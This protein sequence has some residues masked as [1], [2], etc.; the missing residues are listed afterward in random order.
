MKHTWTAT[1]FLIMIFII[2]QLTGLL[3]INEYMDI[4]ESSETGEAVIKKEV[5]DHSVGGAPPEVKNK[6]FSAVMIM[7]AIIVGTGILLLLIKYRL[8]RF[9]KLWLFIAIAICLGKAFSPFVF[10]FMKNWLPSMIS[11]SSLIAVIF[12]ILFGLFKLYRNNVYIHNFTEIFIYGGLC[13]FVVPILNIFWAALLL[14]GISFYDMYAVWHSKHMVTMAKFQS[15]Q[16]MFAG[17]MIPYS[18]K[19]GKKAPKIFT[20]DIKIGKTAKESDIKTA[21]LGGG[22]IAFPLIFSGV[23]LWET[24]S[25][26]NSFIVTITTTAALA[27]LFYIGEKDKFYPAMPFISAGVFLGFGIVKLIPLI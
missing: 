1:T 27:F 8:G 6:M 12:A 11:F 15:K 9:M 19:K 5:Y 18:K 4:K 26:S 20:K 24:G 7:T 10:K 3:I 17:L 23:L 2:A 14:V 13:A 21:I 22:D 16:Q 25:F